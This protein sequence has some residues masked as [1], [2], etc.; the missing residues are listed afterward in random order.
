MNY[1]NPTL[2]QSPLEGLHGPTTLKEGEGKRI[3]I[4]ARSI[5]TTQCKNHLASSITAIQ[6]SIA[7]QCKT[8][9]IVLII[10]H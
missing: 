9:R 3:N 5:S 8:L 4:E 2:T 1:Y 6:T 10:S 7:S